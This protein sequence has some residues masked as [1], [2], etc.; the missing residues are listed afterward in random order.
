MATFVDTNVVVYAY[1]H[2]SPGKRQRATELLRSPDDDLVIS[3]QV[4]SEFYWV[5]TRKLAPPLEP[6]EACRATHLLAS[7]PVVTLDRDLVLSAV[8]TAHD[9]RL[10]LWDAMI[11]EAAVRGGC[12]RL[13]TEDLGHGQVIRGIRVEDPFR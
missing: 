9:H 12:D 11:V 3:T 8:D 13:A 10:A 1:D 4:L 6:T 7:L 2:G 5:A